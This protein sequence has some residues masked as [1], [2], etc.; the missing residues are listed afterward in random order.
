[1]SES[2]L[3]RSQGLQILG[4]TGQMTVS[5]KREE[6]AWQPQPLTRGSV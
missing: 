1:M 4:K 2:V 3:P 5:L 6:A